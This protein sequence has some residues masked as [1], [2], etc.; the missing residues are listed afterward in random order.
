MVSALLEQAR[1]W[2]E[3]VAALAHPRCITMGLFGF[4]AGLPLLLIFGTLSVWLR[5]AGVER[6]TVTFFSWAAL[7]Y[8]FKF[9]WAPLVDRLPIPILTRRLG[10]RRA[11]LLSSQTALA[12][13][14]VITSLGD[15][16][17]ALVWTAI[18]AL[19]IGFTAAT[20]DIVIDAFRIESG[21][22]DWQSLMA[23]TYIA[24]YRMGMITSGAGALWLASE[25]AVDSD[26]YSF[27]AWRQTYLVMAT[28][29]LVGII[30]T[31]R[32]SEP[33][34][35]AQTPTAQSVA[36]P[37]AL[38]FAFA[39]S[40]SAF[41]VSFSLFHS[42]RSEL[43]PLMP[44]LGSSSPL[45]VFA[46]EVVRFTLAVTC[47][48]AVAAISIRIGLVARDEMRRMYV[49]PMRE[50][51]DR[52]GSTAI[53]V[54]LLI[55]T[56]RIAD[57]VMGSVANVFYLDMGYD[58]TQ[59]ATYSKFWGLWATVAGG[60]LGGICAVRYGVYRVLI[61]GAALAAASNLLFAWLATL[62]PNV[63]VLASIIVAD[64][65]SA[66][67]AG[68]AFVAYLSSLTNVSF[69]ATQYALFTSLMTLLPKLLAGYA[70]TIV[71]LI[72]Y[73]AFFTCTAILGV[74]VLGLTVYAARS[75]ATR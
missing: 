13:A 2:R 4:S 40:A 34:R 7:G 3:S 75:S 46:L 5:E 37:G 29:M 27:S 9:V 60:F 52:F 72:D 56:Y 41:A 15:P 6:A 57:I 47:A 11:W 65:L 66:G 74:P 35:S 64:N 54:L 1:S 33:L 28:A 20:Q 31:L 45:A 49:A 50:F 19:L 67:L 39:L 58:K 26:V 16:A 25:L 53:A 30:T 18:G 14:I 32:I 38:L 42:V 17:N 61:A 62:T 71:D 44:R 10:R 12:F 55:G 70:G 36:R 43:I 69:T 51:M 73:P 24:G 22:Q 21:P 8:S 68:A 23:A 48:A 63:T 59:I